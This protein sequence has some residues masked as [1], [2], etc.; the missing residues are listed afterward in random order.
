MR[1]GLVVV[2]AGLLV[3]LGSPA[4]AQDAKAAQGE[5]LFAAQKCSVCH[6]IE[7][8]GNKRF[9]LDGV[10]GSV[11]A[12][13]L[14]LWLVDPKAAEAKTGKAGTPKMRSYEKLPPGDLDAL[15]AYLLSLK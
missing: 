6:S 8:R 2:G 1:L 10:G 5:A 3:P 15:V 12:D 9:P 7:G 14:R 13:M 11:S 4:R